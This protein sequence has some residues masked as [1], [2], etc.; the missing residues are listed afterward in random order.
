MGIGSG[1]GSQIGIAQ[2]TTPGT[3]VTVTRFLEFNKESLQF[4]Q[5]SIQGKGLHA[6]GQYDRLG[7]YVRTTKTVAGSIDMDVATKGMGLLFAHML[8]STGAATQIGSTAAWKQI[9]TP[10]PLQGRSLTIQKAVPQATDGVAKAYTYSGAKIP[11]WTLSNAVGEILTLSLNVDAWDEVDTTPLAA[12]SYPLA[13]VFHFAQAAVKFGGTAAINTG[14][15]SITGGT[16]VAG[17]SAFEL[18]GTNPMATDRF[19]LGSSGLKAEQIENDYRSISGSFDGEFSKSTLYDLFKNATTTP[20]QITYTGSVIESGNACTLDI[21]LPA[22]KF[23]TGTNQVDGPDIVKTK[24]EFVA[25][26]DQTT[27]PIQI[28]YISS[29]VAV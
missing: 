13:E 17:L 18:K 15:T 22:V 6:G 24:L 25:L 21:V 27:T 12:A 3:A 4:T 5:E 28:T 1:L 20:V 29:D 26:D 16:A 19:F 9:H 14:V 23:S 11:E 2:E 8:G 10:G 7:R